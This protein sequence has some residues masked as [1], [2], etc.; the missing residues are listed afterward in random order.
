MSHPGRVVLSHEPGTYSGEWD[1]DRLAQVISN[2]VGNALHHGA[3]HTP[4]EVA[5][6][7]EDSTLVL[8][9][10]NQG[11]PIPEAL[12]PHVFDPF[13][14]SGGG[15]RQGLGLGLYIVQQIL[16]AHGGSI[17]VD[18]RADSGTTFTVRLP[19]GSPPA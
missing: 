9:V 14:G 6:H 8:T 18:S 11:A 7:Q 19:R 5:L 16:Q 15:S 4:V 3:S 17:S 12:L 13:R 2:L 10:H 1:P